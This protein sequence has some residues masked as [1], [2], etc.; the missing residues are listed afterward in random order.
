M[1]GARGGPWMGPG[2]EREINK[3]R[4]PGDT[5]VYRHDRSRPIRSL[6]T[7]VPDPG[8]GL[9]R[10]ELVLYN[11]VHDDSL[12]DND[13]T[14]AWRKMS[15]GLRAANKTGSSLPGSAAVPPGITTNYS[16]LTGLVVK[17]SPEIPESIEMDPITSGGTRCEWRTPASAL[18]WAFPSRSRL[19][20]EWKIKLGEFLS[21][22]P[23]MCFLWVPENITD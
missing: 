22:M 5:L 11:F 10:L 20:L 7:P 9:H 18:L 15:W 17:P 21:K 12:P 14:P 23:G 3:T 1:Y 16:L 8:A 2:N 6:H 13:G 19:P 4:V